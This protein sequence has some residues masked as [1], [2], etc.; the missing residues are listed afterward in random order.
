[1]QKKCLL[2]VKLGSQEDSYMYG[3]SGLGTDADMFP[4]FSYGPHH[5]QFFTYFF[6]AF[7][8]EIPPNMQ[9]SLTKWQGQQQGRLSS[10]AFLSRS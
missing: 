8:R 2:M 10:A 3:T 9:I 4:K 6:R 5:G 1:M 7:K